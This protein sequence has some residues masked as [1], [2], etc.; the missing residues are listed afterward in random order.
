[1]ARRGAVSRALQIYIART[2]HQAA[3]PGA[4]RPERTCTAP[5]ARSDHQR[6]L[7][8]RPR[9]CRGRRRRGQRAARAEPSGARPSQAGPG[10]KLQAGAGG[11]SVPRGRG[12][13]GHTGVAYAEHPII[14]GRRARVGGAGGRAVNGRRRRRRGEARA[15][16]SL[17][18]QRR[19]GGGGFSASGDRTLRWRDATRRVPGARPEPRGR[20]S[21]GVPP[22]DNFS[23]SSARR[24]LSPRGHRPPARASGRLRGRSGGG[25]GPLR[26]H[27]PGLAAAAAPAVGVPGR[28]RALRPAPW[29]ARGGCG[30]GEAA[31]K[32]ERGPAARMVD[33]AGAA[34]AL[35]PGAGAR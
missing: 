14:D 12:E 7:Q 3:G 26:R 1:M 9:V 34:A 5:P 29:S 22:A 33:A 15:A 6:R 8:W 24:L 4:G 11:V 10:A 20:R 32:V 18:P 31:R 28:P 19:A 16:A 21:R 2:P 30:G 27:G 35:A 17:S 25:G 13:G 23:P